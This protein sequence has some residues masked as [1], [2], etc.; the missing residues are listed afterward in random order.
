MIQKKIT[1]NDTN[2]KQ[3]DPNCIINDTKKHKKCNDKK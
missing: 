2:S 3:N 1:K